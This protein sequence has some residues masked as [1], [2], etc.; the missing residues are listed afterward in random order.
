[1]EWLDS[2]EMRARITPSIIICLPIIVPLYILF[3]DTGNPISGL[4]FSGVVFIGISYTVS[5]FVH[6]NGKKIQ[7]ELWKS[8]GG[9]PSSK[10]LRWSDSTFPDEYKLKL[11]KA[12]KEFLDIEL[13]D[14]DN[15]LKN[16]EAADLKFELAFNQAKRIVY[17]KS[18]NDLLGK[19]NAEYGFLR[20]LMG[21]RTIWVLS[22]AIG[23][24][25]C[26]L[27]YLKFNTIGY[28]SGTILEAV[29]FCFA[30]IWGWYISP[31]TVVDPAKQY[32]ITLWE[33]FYLLAQ[34]NKK[35]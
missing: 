1:M 9:P 22:C 5:F 13:F 26:G 12:T 20:N 35:K 31:L 10:I 28:V 15:E 21:N 3:N 6:Y 11:H 4:I 14:K 25:L 18:S 19:F 23:T 16:P 17:N 7:A 32:A 33:S 27:L 8:W 24:S 2:Y 30:L 34:E 29:L